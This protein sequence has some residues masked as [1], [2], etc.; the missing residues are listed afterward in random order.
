MSSTLAGTMS[1]EQIDQ[2]LDAHFR[3]E[4]DG[5]VEA[6]VATFTDDVVHDV[7]GDPAGELRG[8][9]A[10]GARYGHLFGNVTGEG[11]AVKHR[12]YG[13]DFV[14]DDRSGPREW[15]GSSW[16]FRVA[17]VR[18]RPGSCTCSSSATAASHGRTSG[19]TA[20]RPSRSSPQSS[21]IRPM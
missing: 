11:V 5:D 16:G 17:A 1:R 8:T 6:T 3:A 13:D 10:A 15:S 2:I 12:L 19:S 18:Q 4:A 9:D 21:E 20:P 7:V 14:V